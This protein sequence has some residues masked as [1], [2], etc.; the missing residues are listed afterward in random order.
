M[1]NGRVA[2]GRT[3]ATTTSA[4]ARSRTGVRLVIAALALALS[5]G[6]ALTAA[7]AT[8]PRLGDP[9]ALVRRRVAS[10]GGR[11]VPLAG[12]APVLL[13]AV[14]AGED[15]RFYRHHGIDLPGLTRAAAYD[16]GHLSLA[17]GGSTITEQLAKD[18]YLHGNDRSP[19]R[20][21]QAAILAMELEARLS[22][23]QIL[24]DYLNAVYFGAGA[25]G[26]EAASRRYFGVAPSALDLA[27][28]S[29]LAG[30]IRSPSTA[31]PYVD[32]AAARGRQGAVLREMVRAGDVTSAQARAAM[33]TPLPLVAGGSIP[34]RPDVAVDPAPAVSPWLLAL[35]AA[36]IVAGVV[37]LLRRPTAAVRL[38]GWLV[39][40][41]GVLLALRAVRGD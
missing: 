24:D 40:T 25:T 9:D 13:A 21:V 31:D 38:A 17:Q 3:A 28:A 7:W 19:V 20:K 34:G 14:V 39:V 16:V 5:L 36:L 26:I 35:A 33:D 6:L 2:R 18:L 8:A 4:P 23:P 30:L 10:L 15:E 37:A 12:V 1:D 29:L 22:K 32:P 27:Q 11:D 41:A